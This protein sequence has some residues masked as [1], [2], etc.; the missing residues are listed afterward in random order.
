[1]PDSRPKP[2]SLIQGNRTKAE[3]AV[4]AAGEKALT[5]Q[6]K[7]RAP[8]GATKNKEA[9]AY[10]R[11]LTKVLG[12]V[13]LDEA[14]YENTLWRYCLL[15]AEHDQLAAER[16]ERANDL[17]DLRAARGEMDED[18]YF[19]RLDAQVRALDATDR[20]IAKKR[21]QMLS[22]EKENLLT[23]QGK[24]RAIPKKP[25]DKKPSGIEAFRMARGG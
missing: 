10:W 2:L 25:E 4:R 1:M 16:V 23:V 19:K 17:S 12:S 3:I 5:T 18:E 14:F 21:D 22:I 9:Y 24:L 7:M 8:A 20:T 11:R 13:G 6:E 15:L